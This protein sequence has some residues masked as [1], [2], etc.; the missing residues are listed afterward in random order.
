MLDF[1]RGLIL[2][3]ISLLTT[4][5]VACNVFSQPVAVT[6]T[7]DS[8]TLA[9]GQRMAGLKLMLLMLPSVT[10]TEAMAATAVGVSMQQGNEKAVKVHSAESTTQARVP[11]P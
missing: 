5:V 1:S 10:A 7:S 2:V 9:S 6:F 3:L 11:M 8:P 4:E